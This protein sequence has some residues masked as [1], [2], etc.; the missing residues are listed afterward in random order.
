MDH[1]ARMRCEERA[2]K[3]S[4]FWEKPGESPALYPQR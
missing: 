3:M 1:N 2:T 4:A